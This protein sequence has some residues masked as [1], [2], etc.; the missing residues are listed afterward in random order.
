MK[1]AKEMRTVAY[2]AIMREIEESKVLAREFMDKELSKTIE[3]ASANGVMKILVT[4]DKRLYLP[5]II[6]S[7]KDNGYSVNQ[8]GR[9]LAI[10][11]EFAF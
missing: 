1:P 8:K 5:T 7:L 2:D 10:S 11:W 9:T 4:V 6:D 3:E